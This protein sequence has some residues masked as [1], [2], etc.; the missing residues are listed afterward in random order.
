M[1]RR[2]DISQW[3][4]RTEEPVIVW[5]Y[6][7]V[8]ELL[9]VAVDAVGPEADEYDQIARAWYAAGYYQTREQVEEDHADEL[10]PEQIEELYQRGD[11]SAEAAGLPESFVATG[12]EDD[13]S[14]AIIYIDEA[15]IYDT[16]RPV[17]LEEA[18]PAMYPEDLEEIRELIAEARAEYATC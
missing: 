7:G 6:T 5:T 2:I 17:T 11:G 18:A 15:T 8:W 9:P 3:R 16:R 13:G 1:T 12:V 10:T 14:D 4:D